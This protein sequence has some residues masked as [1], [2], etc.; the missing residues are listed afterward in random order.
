MQVKTSSP[1]KG[2]ARPTEGR[3]ADANT[4]P[5]RRE[6]AMS[7]LKLKMLARG[8]ARKQAPSGK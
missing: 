4:S 2:I 5:G 7:R 6:L 1:F 3:A 8:E